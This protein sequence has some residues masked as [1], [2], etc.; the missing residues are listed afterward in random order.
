MISLEC[1]SRPRSICG[2]A[3]EADDDK[4]PGNKPQISIPIIL[5]L[6]EEEDSQNKEAEEGR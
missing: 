6:V 5:A 3:W 4:R 1:M 2:P